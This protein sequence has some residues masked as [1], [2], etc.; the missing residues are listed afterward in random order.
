MAAGRDVPEFEGRRPS[1]IFKEGAVVC[2]QPLAANIGLG[3][4]CLIEGKP[5]MG[6]S[7]CFTTICMIFPRK[8]CAQPFFENRHIFNSVLSNQMHCHGCVFLAE[9][10]MLHFTLAKS[11]CLSDLI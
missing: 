10:Y 8:N 9:K 1:V 6:R 7:K 11:S 2:A 4:S 5:G 3:R